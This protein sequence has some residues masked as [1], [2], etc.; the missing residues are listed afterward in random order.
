MSTISYLCFIRDFKTFVKCYNQI[1]TSNTRDSKVIP[2]L[3]QRLQEHLPKQTEGTG[4][5][6]VEN[7]YRVGKTGRGLPI[8]GNTQT[9]F[10]RNGEGASSSLSKGLCASM[11]KNLSCSHTNNILSFLEV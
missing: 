11:L 10:G 6:C 4:R 9:R 2:Q 8:C 1:P 3:Y 5:W 7:G